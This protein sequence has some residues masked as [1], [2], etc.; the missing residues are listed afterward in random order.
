MR[1]TVTVVFPDSMPMSL[2]ISRQHILAKV[3]ELTT[4]IE[5]L[6]SLGEFSG[7]SEEALARDSIQWA[8][9]PFQL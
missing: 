9:R 2:D 3:W 4:V 7:D 1:A 6:V 8:C 5:V